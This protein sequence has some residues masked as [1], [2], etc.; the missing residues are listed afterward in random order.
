MVWVIQRH[1]FPDRG[2]GTNDGVKG[3]KLLGGSKWNETANMMI[4]IY[5]TCLKPKCQ[6]QQTNSWSFCLGDFDGWRMSKYLPVKTVQP[7]SECS[8]SALVQIRWGWTPVTAEHNYHIITFWLIIN[9]SA[10]PLHFNNIKQSSNLHWYMWR[11]FHTSEAQ[12]SCMWCLEKL[13]VYK[14]I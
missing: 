1:M 2:G 12:G 14:N 8:A 7:N 5:Y 3:R 10:L 4:D 6:N 9:S 11:M 13:G